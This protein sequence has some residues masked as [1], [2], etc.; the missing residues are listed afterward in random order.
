MFTFDRRTVDSSGAFL[1]GEL[2]R[3]DKTLHLP[4]SL[5][6][7]GRDIDLR[8][9][10]TIADENSSFTLTNFAAAGGANP[11][12]KN[13][14]RG[15]STEISGVSV[16]LN[17]QASPLHL[18]GMEL[19]Y[20]I[21]ELAAAQ[22]LGRPIDSQ[23]YDGIKLKHQMDVDEMVYMG[24]TDLGVTGLVNNASVFTENVTTK[25]NASTITPQ[26]ILDDINGLVD[27]V[28]KQ[29][30]YAVCP[31]H[32]LVPP[33]AMAA[34][35]RPVTEAG[36]KSILQYVRE[37]CLSL[38]INGFPIEINPVKWLDGIGTSS[39]GR[40]VAYSKNPMYVRFPMVPL[41]RTPLQYRG[42]YQLTTYYGKLGEVEFVYPETIGYADGIL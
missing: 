13:W 3:L 37:E 22:Q 41:N 27:A 28:W 9:D 29:S 36:S 26:G 30:G 10:V 12:G 6:T 25:W 19:G 15:T 17:K 24:D 21:P 11:V 31:T 5:V 35:V 8:E 2:E 33:A 32:L 4:L 39:S 40:M 34:L 20:S 1:V 16:D 38:R 18:W 7:W 42:I 23:K 14:I